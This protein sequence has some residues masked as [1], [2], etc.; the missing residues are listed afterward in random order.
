MSFAVDSGGQ[1]LDG[2]TD[3]TRTFHYG[4][5]DPEMIEM[6]TAVLMGHIDL[7]RTVVPENTRDA[8]LDLATR[9]YIYRKGLDYRSVTHITTYY[10]WS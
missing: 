7:A 8:G 1:Y 4:N 6:Y 2:T 10:K 5:P 9:Q 3:I